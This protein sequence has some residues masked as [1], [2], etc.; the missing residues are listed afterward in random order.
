MEKMIGRAMVKYNDIMFECCHEHRTIGTSL[1][2]NTSGNPAN[3]NNRLY[4]L[5]D[6]VAE[7]D[8][9]LSTYFEYGHCNEE[10]RR[11]EDP[12]ERKVWKSEVGKLQRFIAHY[13]PYVTE[14]MPNVERHCSRYD[15]Y[16]FV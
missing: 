15:S 14:D 13:A 7:C 8:Y 12:E 4:T 11:S 6:M 9:V 1:S 5:R 16:N 2:E 3:E 10:M